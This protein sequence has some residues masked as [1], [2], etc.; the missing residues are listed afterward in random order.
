MATSF[1]Q[2][3]RAALAVDRRNDCECLSTD[4]PREGRPAP[5]DFP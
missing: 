1:Q 3:C 2:V 4:E 5:G